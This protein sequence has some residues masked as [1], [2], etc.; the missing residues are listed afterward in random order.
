MFHFR[1]EITWKECFRWRFDNLLD[2]GFGLIDT[3]GCPNKINA[4]TFD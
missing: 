4:E 2:K 1:N 3:T